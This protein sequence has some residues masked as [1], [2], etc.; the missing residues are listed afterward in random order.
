MS[1][2]RHSR[3]RFRD[4][5]KITN[6]IKITIQLDKLMT[7]THKLFASTNGL[8]A[9]SKLVHITRRLNRGLTVLLKHNIAYRV[10]TASRHKMTP[11]GRWRLK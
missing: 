8:T 6:Q 11:R 2:I 4:S 5:Y 3:T 10:V 9:R 1:I 7:N